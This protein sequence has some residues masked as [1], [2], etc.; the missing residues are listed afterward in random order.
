ML[1]PHQ[2]IEQGRTLAAYRELA[3]VLEPWL[4]HRE[5]PFHYF[6]D[7]G[8]P[9]AGSAASSI[10]PAPPCGAGGQHPPPARVL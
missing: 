3:R 5:T 10:E 6:T 2:E 9:G 4:Y 7:E 8:T 1:R